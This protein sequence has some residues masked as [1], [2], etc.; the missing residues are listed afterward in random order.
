VPHT[1]PPRGRHD[2][3]PDRFR[4]T[5]TSGI[6][7]RL[8]PNAVEAVLLIMLDLMEE[9]TLASGTAW[10]SLVLQRLH[11]EWSFSP[12]EGRDAWKDAVRSGLIMEFDA[13]RPPRLTGDGEAA[14][15]NL[16]NSVPR[17]VA[18]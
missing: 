5:S 1:W 15:F 9:R 10:R 13:R 7:E 18:K 6:T 4:L 16:R 17:H 2:R 12:G 14:A 3:N 8:E 11:R